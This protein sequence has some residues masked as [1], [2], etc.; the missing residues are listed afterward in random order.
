M[1]GRKAHQRADSLLL[2]AALSLRRRVSQL[3]RLRGVADSQAR[4]EGVLVRES[5]RRGE[6]RR[7]ALGYAERLRGGERHGS[8]QRGIVGGFAGHGSITKLGLADGLSAA[9]AGGGGG[10]VHRFGVAVSRHMQKSRAGAART[11][12]L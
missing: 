7:P 3:A 6:S 11:L 9:M 10:H 5:G 8:R 1:G 2:R 4:R 12:R